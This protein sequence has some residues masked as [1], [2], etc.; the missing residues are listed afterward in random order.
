M[1]WARLSTRSEARSFDISYRGNE[2]ISAFAGTYAKKKIVGANKKEKRKNASCRTSSSGS[3][4]DCSKAFTSSFS[5]RD[6][7]L[8]VGG[9]R[10][11]PS[12]NKVV[13]ICDCV[14]AALRMFV[15]GRVSWS[16]GTS[17]RY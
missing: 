11:L 3:E 8:S 7:Y 10:K 1:G 4:M 9:N 17:W 15:G 12:R 5:T 6:L 16:G 13:K 14:S 2:Y